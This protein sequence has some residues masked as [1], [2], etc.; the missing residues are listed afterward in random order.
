MRAENEGTGQAL[1]SRILSVSQ[2]RINLEV[3]NPR[4][5][6][7]ED[8]TVHNSRAIV[9]HCR[10]S[11]HNTVISKMYER[12]GSTQTGMKKQISAEL[13]ENLHVSLC[14]ADVSV[15]QNIRSSK[16]AMQV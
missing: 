7:L 15:L 4:L 12:M 1:A 14:D 3:I 16:S 11:L 9:G 13:R 5:V 10:I 8:P 2:T 6:F